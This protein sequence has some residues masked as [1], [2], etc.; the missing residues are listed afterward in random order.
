MLGFD[1]ISDLGWHEPFHCVENRQE[2]SWV[3]YAQ[4]SDCRI[5]DHDDTGSRRRR[6]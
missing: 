2:H 3:S 5:F 1:I 6:C 4:G